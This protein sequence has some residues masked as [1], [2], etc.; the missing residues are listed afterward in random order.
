MEKRKR[1]VAKRIRKVSTVLVKPSPGLKV[2]D[3]DREG[4]Y[5]S[6][7]GEHVP[8]S[9]YWLHRIRDG[10]VI[11]I[12]PPAAMEEAPRKFELTI[13]AIDEV[14]DLPSGGR[15]ASRSRRSPLSLSISREEARHRT[16]NAVKRAE[17]LP[18]TGQS[19]SGLP[20]KDLAKI[21]AAA[22]RLE[23][24]RADV[25]DMRSRSSRVKAE[26]LDNAARSLDAPIILLLSIAASARYLIDLGRSKDKKAAKPRR[27]RKAGPVEK[28]IYE[29]L[30]PLFET[31]YTARAT[32]PFRTSDGTPYGPFVEFANSILRLA[33]HEAEPTTVKSALYGRA[34]SEHREA[35]TGRLRPSRLARKAAM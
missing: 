30:R 20:S 16:W 11:E 7:V 21:E 1:K 35:P 13:A 5:L 22:T 12:F 10:D 34:K 6:E 19:A 15:T 25:L 14:I 26:S 9:L 17:T 28:F 23:A 8:R 24:I 3:P 18:P 33:G 29:V 27:N 31:L 2:C 4:Q 32:A